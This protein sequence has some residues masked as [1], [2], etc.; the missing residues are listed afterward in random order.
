MSEH[1]C[2]HTTLAAQ[3]RISDIKDINDAR[4]RAMYTTIEIIAIEHPYC[5]TIEAI[6][7]IIQRS[8]KRKVCSDVRAFAPVE[9]SGGH[10]KMLPKRSNLRTVR[11]I[12]IIVKRPELA[13]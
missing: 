7:L 6:M 2:E 11:L 1:L 3:S 12:D 5:D 4:L 10:A 13:K 9:Q 8:F